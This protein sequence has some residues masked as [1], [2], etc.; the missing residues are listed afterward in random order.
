[1]RYQSGTV[2]PAEVETSDQDDQ[3][4]VTMASTTVEDGDVSV[5]VKAQDAQKNETKKVVPTCK[6]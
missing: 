1:M 5:E 3:G 6:T 2:T 4:D